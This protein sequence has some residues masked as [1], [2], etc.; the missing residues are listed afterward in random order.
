MCAGALIALAGTGVQASPTP[1]VRTCLGRPVT[2]AGTAGDDRLTGTGGRDVIAG[3]G[4]DDVILGD[5]GKDLLCGGEGRDRVHGRYGADYLDGGRGSD[6]VNG[7]P[8]TDLLV[9][10]IGNDRLFGGGA[11]D[12]LVGNGGRDSLYGGDGRHDSDH[13][14]GGESGDFLDGGLGGAD[15]LYGGE[16]DDHLARGLVSYEFALHPITAQVESTGPPGAVGEGSDRFSEVDGIVGSQQPDTLTGGSAHETLRGLAGDDAIAAGAGDDRVDGGAGS[17]ELDGGEGLDLV[18]F[19]DSPAGVTASLR[20]GTARDTGPDSLLGFESLHGSYFDD[21]LTGDDGPNAIDGSYGRNA[22]FGLAGDD[23]VANAGEGDAGDGRDGCF[24]ADVA[25]CELFSEIDYTPFPHVTNP[26]H[27]EDA[28]R[29]G[30][31]RGGAFGGER[32][33]AYVGIR[34]MTPE[35]CWWWAAAEARWERGPCETVKGTKV[36]VRKNR[37]ALEVDV[38]LRRGAYLVAVTWWDGYRGHLACSPL[39]DPACVELYAR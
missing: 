7:G 29:L 22:L 25:S 4:G 30:T 10:G 13:L 16:G 28:E 15:R 11:G 9:G 39:F 31:I 26:V 32:G 33:P 35:G 3:L 20:D 23:E 37:W 1:R 38:S 14:F 18:S 6:E 17:D 12:T 5:D 27:R 2:L 34:R 8:G 24:L 21:S 36:R 19:E